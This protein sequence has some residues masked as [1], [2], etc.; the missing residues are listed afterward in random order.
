MTNEE[1]YAVRAYKMCPDQ[2]KKHIVGINVEKLCGHEPW[3]DDNADITV[4]FKHP[5]V[6][7]TCDDS[8]YAHNTID[9]IDSDFAELY[10]DENAQG[11]DYAEYDETMAEWEK[12]FPESTYLFSRSAIEEKLEEFNLLRTAD[13]TDKE[14]L[15]DDNI[16]A[17]EVI[18]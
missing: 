16:E 3:S 2:F 15:I 10:I 11:G 1:K 12:K 17:A 6:G 13:G 18:S 9:F 14:V 4:Y 7:G 5:V 8:R